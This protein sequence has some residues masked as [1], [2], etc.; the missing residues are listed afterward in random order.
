MMV[1]GL[2]LEVLNACISIFIVTDAH[3]SN[4]HVSNVNKIPHVKDF[5]YSI[6]IIARSISS[7]LAVYLSAF[8]LILPA[9]LWQSEFFF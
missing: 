1:L 4:S 3:D 8:L 2:G 9:R 5:T 6:S 7:P